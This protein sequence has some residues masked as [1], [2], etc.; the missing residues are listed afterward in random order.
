[1]NI[2]SL[3][4]YTGTM[5]MPW[6]EAGHHCWIVDLQH[7]ESER[8]EYPSG[9]SLTKIKANVLYL[10]GRDGRSLCDW[11]PWDM[12]FA[13]PP[14]DHLAVSGAR[15]FK[16]KGLAALVEALEIVE[17]CRIICESGDCPYFLENP[18]STLSTYWRKPDYK[19]DPYQY[20]GYDGGGNDDYTKKTCLWTGGGFVMP[21][22][23]SIELGENSDRIHK[24]SPG[25]N[26]KNIRSATPM[27]FSTAVFVA[28]CGEQVSRQTIHSDTLF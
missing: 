10:V 12:I 13:F 25:P 5:V 15:W 2:L 14:C 22:I 20:G 1:M 9:G 16:E 19:F 27:G 24:C 6:V 8:I 23:R 3:C 4:D 17:S 11:H 7:E 18:I 28:N 21:E 26:R